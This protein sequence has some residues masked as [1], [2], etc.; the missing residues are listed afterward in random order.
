VHGDKAQ[1]PGAACNGTTDD[2]FKLRCDATRRM[3]GAEEA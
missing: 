2:Q 1:K 3:A